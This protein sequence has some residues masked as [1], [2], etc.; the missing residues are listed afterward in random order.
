MEKGRKDDQEKNRIDLIPSEII[1]ELGEIYTH[2]AKKYT[3]NNWRH[4]I[5]YS[6]IY[7]AALRHLLAWNRGEDNDPDSGL[8]HLAHAFW[9]VGALLYYTM[10]KRYK[11]FDDRWISRK[12]Q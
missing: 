10:H 5:N 1:E 11:K 4:G 8:H 7:G 3:D 6:R 9:N 12:E 2:G